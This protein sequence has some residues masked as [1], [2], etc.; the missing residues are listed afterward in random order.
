MVDCRWIENRQGVMDFTRNLPEDLQVIFFG[1]IIFVLALALFEFI[2]IAGKLPPLIVGGLSLTAGGGLSNL[3]DRLMNGGRVVYFIAVKPSFT[4]FVI[5]N[6]ADIAIFSGAILL[7]FCT[8]RYSL[9]GIY[10]RTS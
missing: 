7:L 8:L 5:F 10:A 1:V 2:L 4:H 3:I 9:Q 6:Y